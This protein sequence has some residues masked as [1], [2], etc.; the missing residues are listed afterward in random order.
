MSVKTFNLDGLGEVKI[1]KRR[2]ARSLRLSLSNDGSIKLVMPIWSTYRTG[3]D[4]VAKQA[5]WIN[6]QP[7]P[8]TRL[9]SGIT[10]GKSHVL[11]LTPTDKPKIRTRLANNEAV[12]FYPLELDGGHQLVQT[13]AKRVSLKALMRDSEELILPRLKELAASGG[14]SY[15][16]ANIKHL[17]ARWGSCSSKGDILL[18]LYL[19]QLPWHLIDYVLLHELTHTE[20]F[21][22]GPK[23]WDKM[24]MHIPNVRDLRKEIKQHRPIVVDSS[25]VT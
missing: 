21:G 3:L 25:S 18:S 1:Y 16:S 15:Q 4:F 19:A 20:V 7:K 5:Q 9:S 22:H 17:K 2:G 23:F 11:V 10:I 12:V 6:E 8:D 13:A 24:S 14:F